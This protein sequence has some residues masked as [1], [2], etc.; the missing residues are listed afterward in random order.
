MKC[1]DK[2]RS[3]IGPIPKSVRSSYQCGPRISAV[4]VSVR[5]SYRSGSRIGSHMGPCI[6]PVSVSKM[7]DMHFGDQYNTA[8]DTIQTVLFRIA[9]V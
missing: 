7:A 2:Y 4:L 6:G 5:S 1:D 9:Q 3:S 8:T